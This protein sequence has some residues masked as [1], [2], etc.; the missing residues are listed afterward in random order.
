MK[1]IFQKLNWCTWKES[2]KCHL[3]CIN[4]SKKKFLILLFVQ[5]LTEILTKD[6]SLKL[7]CSK[8]VCINISW[9]L[10][11]YDRCSERVE[12]AIGENYR[13]TGIATQWYWHYWVLAKT[14]SE[15]DRSRSYLRSTYIHI[16][17]WFQTSMVIGIK[18]KTLDGYKKNH[19]QLFLQ[20]N[21]ASVANNCTFMDI[22][23]KGKM[24]TELHKNSYKITEKC[25][26]KFI[27]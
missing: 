16:N 14:G 27:V 17:T 21:D 3:K 18:W 19:Q 10:F 2:K 15:L 12:N 9:P 8:Y 6:Y 13:L 24:H 23:E 22:F 20:Q 4:R 5:N 11:W 7:N 26:A 1:T 25:N